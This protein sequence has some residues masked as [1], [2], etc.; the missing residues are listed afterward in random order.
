MECFGKY[1][2]YD[3]S[4]SDISDACNQEKTTCKVIRSK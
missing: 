2:V 4:F 1:C 3:S